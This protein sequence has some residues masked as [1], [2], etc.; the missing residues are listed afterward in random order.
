MSTS[1]PQGVS[2]SYALQVSEMITKHNLFHHVSTCTG[3]CFNCYAHHDSVVQLI[4][5]MVN[6]LM[7]DFPEYLTEEDKR[8]L[9]ATPTSEECTA[10]HVDIKVIAHDVLMLIDTKMILK[11]SSSS[12]ATSRNVN[13]NSNSQFNLFKSNNN[14]ND[15]L[16]GGNSK[17]LINTN[18][19]Q[20][21]T[22]FLDSFAI[23]SPAVTTEK[24]ESYSITR[25]D[26]LRLK[27][28]I[29]R[30]GSLIHLYRKWK[31]GLLS[32]ENWIWSSFEK[33]MIQKLGTAPRTCLLDG[34]IVAPSYAIPESKM[35]YNDE[36]GEDEESN[37][38]LKLAFVMDIGFVACNLDEINSTKWL[39][40]FNEYIEK[41][42][43]YE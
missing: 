8:F 26:I 5:L 33:V 30:V 38:L 14:G 39:S 29:L 40:G 28:D 1:S 16:N 3:T 2:S 41:L 35:V 10:K 31:R 37:P 18:G 19:S 36:Y 21:G 13:N 9:C 11:P 7:K 23:A 24:A 25:E 17:N 20:N 15:V 22:P 4:E 6:K 42:E 43:N 34:V 12:S 27:R 32:K